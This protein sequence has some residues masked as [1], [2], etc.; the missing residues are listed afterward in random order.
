MGAFRLET[1]LIGDVINVV[2]DTIR[3]RVREGATDSD[4]FVFRASVDQLSLLLLGDS[5]AGFVTLEKEMISLGLIESAILTRNCSRRLRC[6]RCRT[7]R[8]WRLCR[9]PAGLRRPR[10]RGLPR[11]WS[12]SKS[13]T[14]KLSTRGALGSFLTDFMVLERVFSLATGGV[15]LKK[16][17]QGTPF[18]YVE[19]AEIFKRETFKCTSQSTWHFPP[20][21]LLFGTKS[22]HLRPKLLL[23]LHA[24]MWKS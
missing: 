22:H 15:K 3:S 12:A 8:W 16:R 2:H 14:W 20:Y 5:V 19:R 4:G 7:S 1:V 17:I 10:P 24:S 18:I 11:Q 13:Y 21:L 23:I 9:C 6:Y